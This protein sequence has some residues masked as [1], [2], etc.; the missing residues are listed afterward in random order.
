MGRSLGKGVRELREGI[1]GEPETAE[2]A[3]FEPDATR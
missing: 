3:S 2:V 1:S